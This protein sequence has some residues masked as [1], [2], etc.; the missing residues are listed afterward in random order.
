LARSSMVSPCSPGLPSA[1]KLATRASTYRGR[2]KGTVHL[3]HINQV[4]SAC[5]QHNHLRRGA[6]RVCVACTQ[7]TNELH[8]WHT[9]VAFALPRQDTPSFQ[10]ASNHFLCQKMYSTNRASYEW[11]W[12]TSSRA[13]QELTHAPQQ[14]AWPRLWGCIP[15]GTS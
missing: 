9:H 10:Y 6:E 13:V 3:V 8:S 7:A 14:Q 11:C 4:P 2:S 15:G 5:N 12:K 1:S